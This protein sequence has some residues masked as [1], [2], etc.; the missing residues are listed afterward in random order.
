M[1]R[2]IVVPRKYGIAALILAL[3]EEDIMSE[4]VPV[5][6]HQGLTS[7]KDQEEKGLGPDQDVHFSLILCYVAKIITT[8]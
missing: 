5:N 7:T 8:L 2:T 3:K 4:A 1:G 6:M